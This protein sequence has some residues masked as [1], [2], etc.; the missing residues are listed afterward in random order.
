MEKI[1]W[2]QFNLETARD[3]NLKNQVG[4]PLGG[5]PGGFQKAEL[6][7]RRVLWA[8]KKSQS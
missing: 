2:K 6:L 7:A 3:A 1:N 8:D 4:V 5:G